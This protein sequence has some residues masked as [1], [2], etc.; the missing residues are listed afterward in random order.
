MADGTTPFTVIAGGKLSPSERVIRAYRIVEDA[1][2]ELALDGEAGGMDL[3]ARALV[4]KLA[5]RF[6]P[7][8]TFATLA[9]ALSEAA[10]AH[11]AP[12]GAA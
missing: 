4:V 2:R 12:P 3:L 8:K 9:A 7:A 5:L 11:P 10:A 6:G 1:D